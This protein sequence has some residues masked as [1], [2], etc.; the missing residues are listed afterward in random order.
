MRNFYRLIDLVCWIYLPFVV[1]NRDGLKIFRLVNFIAIEASDIV[2]AISTSKH[3]SSIVITR[4][5]HKSE[6]YLF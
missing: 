5:F 4:T 2:D 1:V 3:F 6:L